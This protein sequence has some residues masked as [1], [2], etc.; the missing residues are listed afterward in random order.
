MLAIIAVWREC[1]ARE[2]VTNAAG[3]VGP[4]KAPREGTVVNDVDAKPSIR[5]PGR[6]WSYPQ[7]SNGRTLIGC[8][9]SRKCNGISILSAALEVAPDTV[10]TAHKHRHHRVEFLDFMKRK[11][12]VV[13]R[14]VCTEVVQHDIG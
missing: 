1:T 6:A 2:F 10:T 14:F 11:P 13:A 4:Y 3:V 5:A 12:A 7:V 9:D 8:S